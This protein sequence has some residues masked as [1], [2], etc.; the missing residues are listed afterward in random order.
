MPNLGHVISAS[1]GHS[2]ANAG[3]TTAEA[4]AAV[5]EIAG[6]AHADGGTC[7]AIIAVAWGCPLD[8]ST[9]VE[10]VIDVAR[11]P[12]DQGADEIC[13]GDTI[14][15]TVPGRVVEPLDRVR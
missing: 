1:D 13:L 7:E 5:G 3:R 8:G 6:L 15:T 12:V 2:R 4:V 10:R 9:P 11:R 14:G